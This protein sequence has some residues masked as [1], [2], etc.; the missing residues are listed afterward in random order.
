[1]VQ[2][3]I[4]S[5]LRQL[6][7]K[8]SLK[9]GLLPESLFLTGV[10]CRDKD[11]CHGGA[12]ADISLGTYQKRQVALKRLRVFQVASI[13]D[14]VSLKKVS[15]ILGIACFTLTHKGSASITSY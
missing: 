2:G 14:R 9:S 4:R 5:R 6:I 15:D 11:S 1:M 12:F 7:T 3:E 13:Q 8:F 10:I